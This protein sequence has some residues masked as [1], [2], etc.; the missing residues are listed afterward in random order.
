MRQLQDFGAD[1]TA[2]CGGNGHVPVDGCGQYHNW[3]KKSIFW[4]LPNWETH[5]L[6]HNLDV[7]HIEKNFF[8]NIMNTVL[9]VQGKT[10]D[11]LKSRLDLP[12]I[13][14]RDELHIMANGKGPTPKFRLNASAKEEFFQWILSSFKFPDGY[15][16]NL[17]NC[18]DS[19]EERLSGMKSHDCH[20]FM[21]RLLPFAFAGL[22]PKEVHE[23]IAGKFF[24]SF[25]EYP[26]LFYTNKLLYI[27]VFACDCR[28]KCIFSRPLHKTT[29]P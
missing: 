25:D 4:D 9:N 1:T 22:L 12:S 27:S 7:M 24:F 2:E 28:D 11:N 21:Q 10:K 13:C 8:D 18:V 16:S 20:V 15:A 17:R 3:H 6:R 29:N 23:A 26:K 14:A 19:Q 5:L